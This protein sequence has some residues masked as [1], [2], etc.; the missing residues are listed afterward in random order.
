MHKVRRVRPLGL[1]RQEGPLGLARACGRKC[2]GQLGCWA[3]R[4]CL[5]VVGHVKEGGGL[6]QEKR[7][8]GLLSTRPAHANQV[9]NNQKKIE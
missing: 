8:S 9:F 7:E 4:M 6:T 5:E 1:G 2:L 3:K